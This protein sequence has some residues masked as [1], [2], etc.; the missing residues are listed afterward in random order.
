MREQSGTFRNVENINEKFFWVRGYEDA[1]VYFFEDTNIST[2]VCRIVIGG[3]LN[4]LTRIWESGQNKNQTSDKVLLLESNTEK[5]K[6]FW[7]KWTTNS[8]IF[9]AGVKVGVGINLHLKL[10]LNAAIKYISIRS[11]DYPIEYI[12]DLSCSKIPIK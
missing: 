6:P 9:G 10:S 7:I 11:R 3:D 12:L 1:V 5:F 8:I 2:E 4:T